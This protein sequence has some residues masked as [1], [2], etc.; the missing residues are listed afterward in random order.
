VSLN[1]LK[2]SSKSVPEIDE[3]VWQQ[4]E[5]MFT[6]MI[7]YSEYWGMLPIE[8]KKNAA[9]PNSA[10]L[11][12]FD[13]KM[14][15]KEAAEYFESLG[16]ITADQFYDD[17]ERFS[18]IA[19]TASRISQQSTIT[20]I[21]DA[22]QEQLNADQFDPKVLKDTIQ[23]IAISRGESPINPFHME[24]IVQNNVQT[25]YNKGRY[26]QLK[27]SK[28]PYYQYFSVSDDSTSD[29]CLFLDGKVFKA[30]DPRLDEYFPQNHHY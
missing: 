25:A 16:V 8:A 30:D 6:K 10:R 12:N 23:S 27:E 11:D 5:I 7:A 18:G 22:I 2:D 3:I 17:L 24:L 9:I 26:R 20:S 19:F 28:M 21:K 13:F 14:P 1:S 29:L 4:Y 15:Y